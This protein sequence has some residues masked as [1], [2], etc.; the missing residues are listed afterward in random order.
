MYLNTARFAS[1]LHARGDVDGVAP[2]V[3]VRLARADHAG[4]DGAVVDAH[5]QH[6]V[7][8]RLLVDG[9]QHALQLQREL[10]QARQVRPADQHAVWWLQHSSGG[11]CNNCIAICDVFDELPDWAVDKRLGSNFDY[12]RLGPVRYQA[13]AVTDYHPTSYTYSQVYTNE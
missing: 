5:A 11:V 10:H 6:E 1:A 3:V 4:G 13:S 12:R 2:Y 9:R 7:V 8:E